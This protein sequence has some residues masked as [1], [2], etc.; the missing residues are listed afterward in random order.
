MNNHLASGE[1]IPPRPA[2]LQFIL[3]DAPTSRSSHVVQEAY[4]VGGSWQDSDIRSQC[5]CT[6]MTNLE[7]QSLGRASLKHKTAGDAVI[8]TNFFKWTYFDCSSL[9]SSTF[10]SVCHV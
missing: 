8:A 6:A 9:L 3:F 1:Q 4:L 10:G 7:T 5:P 2:S